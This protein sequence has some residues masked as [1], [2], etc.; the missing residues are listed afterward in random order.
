MKNIFKGLII[1]GVAMAMIVP[2]FSQQAGPT[3]GSLQGGSQQG[4][5]HDGKGGGA[6][7]LKLNKEVLAKIDPPLNAD[8]KTK[9]DALEKSTMAAMKDLRAKAKTEDK[10]QLRDAMKKITTDYRNGLKAI[11]TPAQQTS[12]QKLYKE[13]VAKAKQ[14]AKGGGTKVG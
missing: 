7:L 8:Q 2:A 11:L 10:T 13:A 1:T 12:Y 14:D 4:G 3:N 5:K 9:V 6:R